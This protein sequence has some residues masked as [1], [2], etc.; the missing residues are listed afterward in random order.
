[1][2]DQPVIVVAPDKLCLDEQGLIQSGTKVILISD[3][4]MYKRM[5]AVLTGWGKNKMGIPGERGGIE[6]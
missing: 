4:E 1:M 6:G 2:S 3:P 5:Q